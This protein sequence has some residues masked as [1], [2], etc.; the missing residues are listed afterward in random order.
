M[1]S[2]PASIPAL[3][4]GRVIPP[5]LLGPLIETPS[6]LP[7]GETLRAGLA[8]DGYL[9]LR[10]LIDPAEIKAAREEVFARLGEVGEI[11]QPTVAGVFSGQSNRDALY[12]DRGV[13]W[14]SVSEGSALRQV[15]HG[16][17]LANAMTTAFGAPAVG[18]DY[19][20]VRPVPGGRFTH[21][22][23]D[24]GFF[25]RA[26][27]RVLTCWIAYTDIDLDRG[28]LFVVENSH[29]FQ[30]IREKFGDFDVVRNSDRKASIDD[31]PAD[32]ARSRGTRLLTAHFRPGD[33]LV[34]GMYTVHGALE[35]H[36]S[37]NRVR[38][39]TDIRYQPASEPKDPRYFGPNP[40]GTTGAG[41]GE[42]NGARPLTEDWHIR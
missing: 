2:N 30:D 1:S 15:T 27:E 40:G 22:H 3:L 36:A 19:L 29:T 41:Y 28:P 42:L 26:T 16:A 13:F 7:D 11:S 5:E 35:H 31:H 33:V 39:T 14:Q 8:R 34:F 20:F 24:A 32:F 6:P 17:A 21:M 23:C 4:D 37:D 25:A 10:D 9:L 12:E 18:F 38:L